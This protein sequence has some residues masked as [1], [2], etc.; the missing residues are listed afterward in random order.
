MK[1]KKLLSFTL[2]VI[3]LL[4]AF[5]MPTNAA[6]TVV[7]ENTVIIIENENISEE[8][9]AKIIAYYTNEE[10]HNN[11][12]TTYGLTCTLFGHKLESSAVTTITHK[13]RSSSPRCLQER[14]NYQACTR[15]DYEIS[16]LISSS[17]IICCK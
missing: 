8:T 3:M 15:C 13:V 1:I 11:D 10:E 7:D 17:Y 5:I 6:E 12:S 16:T 14:Y 2:T 4:S 9:K